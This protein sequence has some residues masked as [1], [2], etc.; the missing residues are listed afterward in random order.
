MKYGM[1]LMAAALIAAATAAPAVPGEQVERE[2]RRTIE[3]AGLT[4]LTVKNPRG[5]TVV[6]GKADA[7]TVSI[8][9]KKTAHGRNAAD[10]AELLD[11]LEVEIGTRGGAVV[12]ETEDD[13][14]SS[15]GLWSFFKGGRRSA[16]VDY[17]V[18]VP[19]AFN[20]SAAAASGEVR[21]SNIGGNAEVKGMS[22]D[23]S[24]R[25]VA[26]NAQIRIMSGNL[27]AV[28]IGGDVTIDAASGDGEVE[29]VKGK[30][31]LSGASGD[32]RAS[33]IGGDAEVDLASGDFVLEGCSGNVKF[34]AASG[35]ARIS[36]VTG[37][38]KAAASSG[39]LDVMIIPVAERE[40]ELSSSSGDVNV[41]YVAV[42]EFGFRLDVKTASGSIEGNLPI[43][44]SRVDRRRLQGVVGKGG[45][46]VDIE[47][48]SGDV[49]IVE[50]DEAALK[51]NR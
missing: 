45:A 10:A 21:L 11:R 20:V 42:P 32:F 29:N 4:E 5:R 38:I 39:D 44:V 33:R 2:D 15:K 36:E 13:G 3:A 43:K 12:I 8:V 25:A 16:R 1:T 51:Y 23:I 41:Y 37:S 40:F 17:T 28:D 47:T 6:V 46:S 7:S 22:G 24:V 35:D 50:R 49:T 48:A 26:G 34:R 31:R 27:E 9:V 14:R 19:Y 30:L 18:E